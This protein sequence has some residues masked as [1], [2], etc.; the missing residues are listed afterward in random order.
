MKTDIREMSTK[1]YCF[2]SCDI[3]GHSLDSDLSTQTRR[4]GELNALMRNVLTSEG[5]NCAIWAS[6]GDGGH[7][8][9]EPRLGVSSVLELII[10]LREWSAAKAVPLRIAGHYG[11]VV[12]IMGADDRIQLVG[13]GINMC[14]TLLTFGSET[15]V[16][17]SEEF[18]RFVD[19]AGMTDTRFLGPIPVY[20][21]QR[22]PYVLYLLSI[23][24]RFESKW[25]Q[26]SRTEQELLQMAQGD[27]TQLDKG[28]FA[29]EQWLLKHGERSLSNT[30][31]LPSA[32]TWKIVYH[33]KRLLQVNS[34]DKHALGA[35]EDVALR[36]DLPDLFRGWDPL[37]FVKFV[38][39]SELIERK[40]GEVFCREGD[41]GDAMFVILIGEIGVVA[42]KKDVD[43]KLDIRISAGGILGELA[44]ILRGTRTAT[45]QAVGDAAALSFNYGQRRRFLKGALEARSVQAQFDTL[46]NQRVAEFVCNHAPYFVGMSNVG[47]LARVAENK[48]TRY[49]MHSISRFE[50]PYGSVISS[51]AE[52]FSNTGLYIL[53]SGELSTV[54]F[55]LAAENDLPIIY[56][57]FN[58]K[59][60][61]MNH[62]YTVNSKGGVSIVHVDE[63]VF[64]RLDPDGALEL[65]E[66]VTHAV[67]RTLLRQYK[68]DIFVSYNS[69]DRR[70]A[71]KWKRGMENAGLRVYLNEPKPGVHFT[72][73]LKSALL[74]SATFVPIVSRHLHRAEAGETKSWVEMEIVFR[75]NVFTNEPNIF[76]IC[77]EGGDV[78]IV[79]DVT[80]IEASGR[81]DEDVVDDVVAAVRNRTEMIPYST[82]R[83][84]GELDF[85]QI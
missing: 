64:E 61:S 5:G 3:V 30:S 36:N 77:A 44:V 19:T 18:R 84:A 41:E 54:S 69:T 71:E 23:E 85:E 27:L 33:A 37:M 51:D 12:S 28:D 82:Q 70:L 2:V 29:I 15:A 20:I 32:L 55:T 75:R 10:A 17:V 14:G 80:H 9:L 6:G 66:R 60:A 52:E 78:E 1:D 46:F 21:K 35:L 76:P 24:D 25:G 11:P 43:Q 50:F 81:S 56:A 22:A 73:E 48:R 7:L 31:N 83:V 45:L 39:T 4:V 67:K 49:L 53:A 57:E 16:V 79:R 65:F 42:G 63:A 38:R 47:P 74:T 58:G 8:A 62:S 59:L 26:P 40:H 34:S 72:P 13:D 68:F